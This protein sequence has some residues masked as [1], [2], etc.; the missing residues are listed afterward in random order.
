MLFVG[1]V[2]IFWKRGISVPVIFVDFK[3]SRAFVTLPFVGSFVIVTPLRI[4]SNQMH[5]PFGQFVRQF[6]QRSMF[7]LQVNHSH[8]KFLIATP[9]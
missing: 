2:S 3:T 8:K 6:H 7:F 5:F 1:L 4:C 9:V